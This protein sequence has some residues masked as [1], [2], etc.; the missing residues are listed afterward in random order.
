MMSIENVFN[1]TLSYDFKGLYG[2][3]LKDLRKRGLSYGNTK[4]Y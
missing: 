1:Y 2:M 3:L 4:N